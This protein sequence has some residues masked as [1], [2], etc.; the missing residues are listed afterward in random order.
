[1]ALGPAGVQ[2]LGPHRDRVVARAQVGEVAVYGRG[3]VFSERLDRS[4]PIRPDCITG[5]FG[6]VR[7]ELN[8]P[9]V[10]WRS[11]RLFTAAQLAADPNVSVSRLSRTG[12]LDVQ[13]MISQKL[14]LEDFNHSIK[15]MPAGNLIRTVP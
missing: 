8:M 3:F 5:F 12:R 4:T 10:H 1:L 7:D 11:P 2:L 9:Q 15:E 6:R 13:R 14:R